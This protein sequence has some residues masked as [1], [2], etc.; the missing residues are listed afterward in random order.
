MLVKCRT[1][2][3]LHFIAVKLFDELNIICVETSHMQDGNNIII[4][5]VLADTWFVM[6]VV[7]LLSLHTVV[8]YIKGMSALMLFDLY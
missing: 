2:F 3:I 6:V 5:I 7:A 8:E 4:G 1:K